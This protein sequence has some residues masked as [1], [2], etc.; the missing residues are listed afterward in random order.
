MPKLWKQARTSFIWYASYKREADENGGS[1]QRGGWVDLAIFI[2][3]SNVN[4]EL[5]L[6][7]HHQYPLWEWARVRVRSRWAWRS[8][9]RHW[10]LKLKIDS[11][12]LKQHIRRSSH[13]HR[14]IA[15][16]F[17]HLDKHWQSILL[18]T[19]GQRNRV[20]LQILSH[21]SVSQM[22]VFRSQWAWVSPTRGRNQYH[23]TKH[24]WPE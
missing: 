23:K 9:A 14:S 17:H 10:Q 1:D 16:S 13:K 4:V 8:H 11:S 3:I 20:L 12:R 24:L 7:E 15:I 21:H 22:Y 6:I 18:Q 19:S 5:K 2:I